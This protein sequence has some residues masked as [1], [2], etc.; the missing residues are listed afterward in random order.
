MT[1]MENEL[2]ILLF[3]REP[4]LHTPMYFLLSH[5]SFM[6]I[7][8]IS[9]IVP[10][11]ITDFL[12][13]S[14]DI[15]FTGCGTQLFLCLMVLCGECLLLAAISCD[16]CVDIC[17]PLYYPVLI[18]ERVSL[19]LV[20]GCW[21]VYGSFIFTYMRPQTYHTPC[22]DKFLAIFY[23]IVMPT[24]NPVI[25]SFWSKDVLTAMKNLL[26]GSFLY[27]K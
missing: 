9:N 8:H 16:R 15:S 14:R 6:D 17:H 24:L 4:C 3:C 19:H 2:M 12:S 27:K 23:T 11:V 21:L 13:G 25:Y 26:R 5:L 1:L 18:S 22:Q 10:K 20:V 7:M